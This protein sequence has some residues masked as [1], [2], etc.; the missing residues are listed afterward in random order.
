MKERVGGCWSQTTQHPGF[1]RVIY[2]TQSAV[3]QSGG[4][5][6]SGAWESFQSPGALDELMNLKD[7]SGFTQAQPTTWDPRQEAKATK[8]RVA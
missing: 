2:L 1:R 4:T 7:P 5:A 8:S 3:G 6:V